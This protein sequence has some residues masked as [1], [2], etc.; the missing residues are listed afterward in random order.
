MAS[1]H[2]E[3]AVLVS[4]LVGIEINRANSLMEMGWFCSSVHSVENRKR[5][6]W[7]KVSKCA[8]PLRE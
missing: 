1:A 2:D 7:L 8:R 3:R 6:S 4:L 5:N